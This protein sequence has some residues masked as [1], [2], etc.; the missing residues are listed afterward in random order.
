[1]KQSST[2]KLYSPQ[3]PDTL[4]QNQKAV[5]PM[6]FSPLKY[7]RIDLKTNETKHR[8][9]NSCVFMQNLSDTKKTSQ[10]KQQAAHA[11]RT[12]KPQETLRLN[13]KTQISSNS[14][15]KP[16]KS[17]CKHQNPSNL[18]SERPNTLLRP[19]QTPDRNQ[20]PVPPRGN[21]FPL[22]SLTNPIKQAQPS[23]RTSE[24]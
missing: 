21:T 13:P 2:S 7:N 22:M 19:W 17:P 3:K 4:W 24:S 23:S 5:P 1:M 20:S 15:P 11:S 10:Q 16:L 8:F 9:T 18:R 6:T 14:S 12:Q